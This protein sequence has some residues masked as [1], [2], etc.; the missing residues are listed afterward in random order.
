LEGRSLE[1]PSRIQSPV[2]LDGRP[3]ELSTIH[4]LDG[5]VLQHSTSLLNVNNNSVPSNINE[6]GVNTPLVSTSP[7][8][9]NHEDNSLISFYSRKDSSNT[10]LDCEVGSVLR[11][12]N[13]DSNLHNNA[14]D[15]TIRNRFNSDDYYNP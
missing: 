12:S 5:R 3:I 4:E 2:E 15:S 14:F 11:N 10:S 7:H 6:L 13:L 9:I 8:P 1:Y